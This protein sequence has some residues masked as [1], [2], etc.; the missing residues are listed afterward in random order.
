MA[1]SRPEPSASPA[2]DARKSG[3]DPR[4]AA[5]SPSP[6]A[7]GPGGGFGRRPRVP[8]SA[9]AVSEL[10]RALRGGEGPS[11]TGTDPWEPA[12]RQTR[13]CGGTR[14]PRGGRGCGQRQLGRAALGAAALPNLGLKNKK[15]RKQGGRKG[16]R[17][18]GRRQRLPAGRD[19]AAAGI[20]GLSWGVEEASKPRHPDPTPG[21]SRSHSRGSLPG[22]H[23][24][25]PGWR[26]RGCASPNWFGLPRLAPLPRGAK[27]PWAGA[28]VPAGPGVLPARRGGDTG[29]TG[30]REDTRRAGP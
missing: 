15:K 10:G 3:V 16:G 28:A 23:P 7:Q 30:D 17:R 1:P 8:N 5:P 25:A 29:D 13:S 22:Q 24:S 18:Q 20:P 4:A 6:R 14:E 26:Q 27:H 21:A 19:G 9:V 11:A 12:P 2:R